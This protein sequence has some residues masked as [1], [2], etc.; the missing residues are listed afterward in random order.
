M[1]QGK[2]LSW[3]ELRVGIFVLAG[4]VVVGLGIFYVTGTG[5][6]G[7]KYRLV[8]YLPEVSGLTIGPPVTLDGVLVGNVSAVTADVLLE[9]AATS[10]IRPR[11]GAS[12][13]ARLLPATEPVDVKVAA[14][15]TSAAVDSKA[16]FSFRLFIFFPIASQNHFEP[17]VETDREPR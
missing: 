3:N 1:A 13:L 14:T 5:A 4:I 7:A 2:Q 8:T 9:V 17:C 15:T 11:T 16:D 6:L 12:S 10:S